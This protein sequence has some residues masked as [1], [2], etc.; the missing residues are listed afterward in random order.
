MKM[1]PLK[2]LMAVARAPSGYMYVCERTCDSKQAGR[3]VAWPRESLSKKLVGSSRMTICGR[4][5]RP[6]PRTTF[7]YIHTCI[8]NAICIL[9]R[10]WLPS[11]RRK[12][13]PCGC[14]GR[15]AAPARSRRSGAG[16]HLYSPTHTYIHVPSHTIIQQQGQVRSGLT[17]GELA[18]T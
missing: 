4:F 12:A 10:C 11:V 7:T 1:P 6:A 18:L 3:G 9:L 14:A 17:C 16:S 13:R 2:S 15:T 5:H 8:S